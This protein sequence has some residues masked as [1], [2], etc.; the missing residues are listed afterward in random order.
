MIITKKEKYA[1][2]TI[3]AYLKKRKDATIREIEKGTGI[4]HNTIK[5]AL[6]RNQ[7]S[8]R[9]FGRVLRSCRVLILPRKVWAY[10]YVK[11]D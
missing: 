4:N 2:D 3:R 8:S 10:S 7:N 11:Y 5:G 1:I 6:V 9:P